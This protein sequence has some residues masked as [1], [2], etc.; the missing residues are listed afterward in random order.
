MPW[1][2]TENLAEFEAAAGDL[3]RSDP[4]QHT[5]ALTALEA[6]RQRG[7]AA[8]GDVAPAFG[9]HESV[10]AQTD[11]A[12]LQT[13]PFPV[14][15]AALPAGSGGALLESLRPHELARLN[16]PEAAVAEVSERWSAK[17]GGSTAV[18]LRSRLHRL[19]QL[20]PPDPFPPGAARVADE[21]DHDLLVRWLT[22]FHAQTA[23][24]SE[25]AE[26]AV[27]G[28]LSYG[29]LTLWECGGEPVAMAGRTMTVAGVGRVAPVYTP[30]EHRN[31]GY[32][33]A[34]TTA[35]TEQ[36]LS[37]G[38]ADVVLFTDAANPTSNALY[39]RLGYRPIGDRIVLALR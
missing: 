30:S 2:R 11:G 13:P 38:A 26:R 12:F 20:T 3:L 16:L 9:W 36:A 33:A 15:V 8:F 1:R 4:A 34:V 10:P 14:L 7:N 6:M 29:G 24:I 19:F 22:A 32:G 18:Q 5:I 21:S 35:V 17:T 25:D 31:H 37:S 27:A 39:R 28:R 23:A